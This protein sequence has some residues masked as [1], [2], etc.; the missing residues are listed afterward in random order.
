MLTKDSL[1]DEFSHFPKL[2]MLDNL[3]TFLYLIVLT[4]E[5]PTRYD[6]LMQLACID[7]SWRSIGEGLRVGY[8]VLKGF[9]E[10]NKTN[11]TRLSEIIQTWLDMN[12]Q[13]EGAPVTWMTILDVVKGPLVQN[14]ALA[15][16]IYE[17][18]K[19]GS[20]E[21]QITQSKYIIQ[22]LITTII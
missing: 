15:M 2:C 19:Q 7:A 3:I 17:N 16:K 20:S 14:K 13:D 22:S 9:D 18:L 10:S 1:T 11:Q 5:R 21:Q 6:L 8:N 12:G 4:V